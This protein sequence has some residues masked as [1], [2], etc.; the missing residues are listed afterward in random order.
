MTHYA[1]CTGCISQG[2]CQHLDVVRKRLAGLGVTSVKWR[3]KYRVDRFQRG[4]PVWVI[5]QA[6]MNNPT[7]DEYDRGPDRNTFPGIFIKA[8][9]TKALVFIHPGAQSKYER[10]AF[11]GG[12]ICKI[13]LSRIYARDAEPEE[14]CRHCD[15]P[16]SAPHPEGY[17][18]NMPK[19]EW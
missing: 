17:S 7:Y 13:P 16:A 14:V 5:T 3:C 4:A 10:E 1:T 9:G 15:R 18:C 12:P 8:M 2:K 11:V 19:M 6:D